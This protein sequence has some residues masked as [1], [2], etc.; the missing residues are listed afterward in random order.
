MAVTTSMPM[1]GPVFAPYAHQLRPIRK[2][3]TALATTPIAKPTAKDAP[4]EPEHLEVDRP[5]GAPVQAVDDRQEDR[6]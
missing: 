3:M 2:V 6:Q 1:T 5:A 4:P